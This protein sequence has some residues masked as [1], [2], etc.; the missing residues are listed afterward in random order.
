FVALALSLPLFFWF[1][2]VPQR[3]FAAGWHR[4]F[5]LGG[6][7]IF[8]AGQIF[9][10]CAE[11][12]FF[13]EFRSRFNTVAVDYLLYP[14]EVFINIWDTYPVAWVIVVCG[15][16]A[17]VWVA[18]LARFLPPRSDVPVGLP[19]RTLAFF[20]VVLIT[21]LWGRSISLTEV[22]VSH[23]RVLNEIANNAALSF[24]TAS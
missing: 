5:V 22:R 23:E 1:W 16:L 11:Y 15:C 13:E 10:T 21:T 17:A 8:F 20:G 6:L 7:L 2:L 3:W 18:V 4:A 9:L 14:H 19:A 12:Y 24:V